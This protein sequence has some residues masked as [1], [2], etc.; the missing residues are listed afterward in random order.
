MN[1][2]IDHR[3]NFGGTCQLVN[4]LP[5]CQCM[6][7]PEEYRPVCGTDRVTYSNMC[8]LRSESCKQQVMIDL[9]YDGV[10]DKC[11]LI[12]CPFYG[13]CLDDGSSTKCLCQD[14]CTD[15]K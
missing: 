11:K 3:C 8:K 13:T 6:E 15:V 12:T 9:A 10:C 5:V 14:I 7:C 2:C 1:P 4:G